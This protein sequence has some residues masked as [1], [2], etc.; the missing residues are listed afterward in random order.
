MP[1]SI[2]SFAI[3]RLDHS[4][5]GYYHTRPRTFI[6]YSAGQLMWE[7]ARHSTGGEIVVY[8]FFERHLGSEGHELAEHDRQDHQVCPAPY[9]CDLECEH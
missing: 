4:S 1:R 6:Q 3:L 8:P 5:L 9:F 2:G 7:I